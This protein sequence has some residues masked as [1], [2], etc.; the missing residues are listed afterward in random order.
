MKMTDDKP[1]KSGNPVQSEKTADKAESRMKSTQGSARL[2]RDV[3]GKIGQ[4]LRAMYDDVV[5][6]GVP[7]RFRDMLRQLDNLD[8]NSSEGSRG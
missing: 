4:Q 8:D 5:K 2:G 1:D 6:E 7:D 3:Q